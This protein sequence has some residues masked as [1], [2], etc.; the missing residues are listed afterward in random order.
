MMAPESNGR[1]SAVLGSISAVI[2]THARERETVSVGADG[3]NF[4]SSTALHSQTY[5]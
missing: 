5:I 4:I 3:A 2:T 1:G